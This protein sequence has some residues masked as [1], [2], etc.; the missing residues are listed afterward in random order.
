MTDASAALARS[1]LEPLPDPR[2]AFGVA[3][4]A[5]PNTAVARI[6]FDNDGFMSTSSDGYT[7]P[8]PNIFATWGEPSTGDQLPI[9]TCGS[10]TVPL[11]CTEHGAMPMPGFSYI[12]AESPYVP[13]DGEMYWNAGAETEPCPPYEK[14]W[15]SVDGHTAAWRLRAMHYDTLSLV[16]GFYP[17]DGPASA[18]S[19]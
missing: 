6:G 7:W 3:N 17:F 8:S 4:S 13:V 15:P 16:H 19:R 2:M 14:G 1:L 18:G 5:T 9:G 11:S 10:L 12:E